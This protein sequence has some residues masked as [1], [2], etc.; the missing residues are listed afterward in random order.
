[1]T[2]RVH[3]T[4]DGAPATRRRR[5]FT[6][7]ELMV[8]ILILA[9]L[10]ALII[11]KVIGR[12]DDAKRAQASTNITELEKALEQFRVDTDR[13]PTTEEGLDALRQ[14]PADIKNW[15]GPYT[16]KDIPPDPWGNPFQYESDGKTYTIVSY[17]A[18]GAEG[19]EGND[20]DI[21][22]GDTG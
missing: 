10:A 11:P 15:R 4:Y 9:I 18:D 21:V 13:Y 1:M 12:T 17:G 7:I 14:E 20:Q 3:A 5:G 16:S 8:V 6:L 2:T 22:G 19:G